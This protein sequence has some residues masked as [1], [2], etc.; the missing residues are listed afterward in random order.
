MNQRG[1]KGHAI[2]SLLEGALLLI[3]GI[4][5]L[6]FCENRDAYSV[7]LTV[8]GIMILITSSLN[9][10]FDI[11]VTLH[12][13]VTSPVS[14]KRG[15]LFNFS[16][17]LALGIAL[18][19]GGNTFREAGNGGDILRVFNFGA[20]FIGLTLNVL[21]GLALLYSI[22]WL[23]RAPKEYKFGAIATFVVAALCVT[24]GI[25][26][27]VLIWN[28]GDDA[29]MRFIFIFAGIFLIILSLLSLGVG[30]FELT[31]KNRVSIV[32]HVE[33]NERKDGGEDSAE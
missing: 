9:L 26:V 21:G 16:L 23:V 30:I 10:V 24:F 18:I 25:L 14:M 5:L 31:Q 33:D 7:A 22:I 32:E 20:L 27:L 1:T 28:S 17:E 19:I 6:V 2:Y 29:L 3:A 13:P 12:S 15:T 4:L 11:I 8:V